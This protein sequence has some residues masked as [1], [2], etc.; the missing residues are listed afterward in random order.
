MLRYVRNWA[1][2]IETMKKKHLK[3]AKNVSKS[4]HP[5]FGVRPLGDRVIVK[6]TDDRTLKT[7]G[8][9]I[10]PDTVKE[11]KGTRRGK[12]VAVGSGK[13]EDG[14]RMAIEVSVGDTIL[15]Q[16]G[17]PISVSGEEYMLVSESN[18]MAIVG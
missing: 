5:E 2:Y 12:V 9:I 3:K 16:W 7:P 17:D 13:I 8:G 14:K 10:I 4:M 11:D 6:E 1:I 18:I 15:F